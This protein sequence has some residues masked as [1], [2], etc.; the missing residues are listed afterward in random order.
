MAF[1]KWVE[2]LGKNQRVIR[3]LSSGY[4]TAV[5]NSDA[6]FAGFAC[7]GLKDCSFKVDKKAFGYAVEGIVGPFNIGYRCDDSIWSDPGGEFVTIDA[8]S[9]GKT[10]TISCPKLAGTAERVLGRFVN[11]RVVNA[12]GG[13]KDPWLSV[14]ITKVSRTIVK[15]TNDAGFSWTLEL[16]PDASKLAVSNQC[17][18]YQQGYTTAALK[19]DAN[20]KVTGIM[21]PGNELYVAVPASPAKP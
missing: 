18:Y 1:Q 7:S 15:W 4:G 21:G 2:M 10:A 14:T 11:A 16:T 20:D 19:V 9:D 17:S 6:P 3:V 13:P 8:E 5:Q 12:D